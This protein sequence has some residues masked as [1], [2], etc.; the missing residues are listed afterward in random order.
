[1]TQKY[2]KGHKLDVWLSDRAWADLALLPEPT[3]RAR[4]EAALALA[5]AGSTVEI[6]S[7]VEQ[8]RDCPR[9]EGVKALRV[10]TERATQEDWHD[11]GR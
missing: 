11:R 9:G 2:R 5:V 4:V 10:L 7:L 1:M 3:K 6:P 8:A